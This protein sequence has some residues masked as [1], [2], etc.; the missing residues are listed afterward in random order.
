MSV[1][2]ISYDLHKEP[3]RQYVELEKALKAA[4]AWCHALESTWYVKTALQPRQMVAYLK[5]YLHAQ[6]K[7][8]VTPVALDRGWWTQGLSKEVLDWLREALTA[9]AVA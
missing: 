4:G 8:A 7:I 9:S 6:D 1:L 5:P 2:T 3:S